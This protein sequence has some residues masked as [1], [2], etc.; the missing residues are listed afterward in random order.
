MC[1]CLTFSL[2]GAASHLGR[3]L[4]NSAPFPD[5]ISHG[6]VHFLMLI[7]SALGHLAHPAA[8]LFLFPSTAD[9]AQS[10]IYCGSSQRR[11]ALV[12]PCHALYKVFNCHTDETA[13]KRL[14]VSKGVESPT[15]SG[16]APPSLLGGPRYAS[17]TLS[18]RLLVRLKSQNNSVNTALARRY[19]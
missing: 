6:F 13:T 8:A 5:S 15:R 16:K 2:V 17:G 18:A 9:V 14:T 12:T 11:H 4:Q 19:G 1:R 10:H 3:W 7:R